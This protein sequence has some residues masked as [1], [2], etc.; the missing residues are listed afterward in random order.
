MEC[1]AEARKVLRELNAELAAS[2]ERSGQDL[3]W[4]AAERAILDAIAA[5]ID[6]GVDLARH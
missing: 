3:S 1:S 4:T 2:S 6:R 5:N